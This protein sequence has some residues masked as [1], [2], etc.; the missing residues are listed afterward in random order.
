MKCPSE[1]IE[2]LTSRLKA[3]ISSYV[4]IY[5]Y[6]GQSTLAL[7][8]LSLLRLVGCLQDFLAFSLSRAKEVLYASPRICSSFQNSEEALSHFKK[9]KSFCLF[10]AQQK[11]T[12]V[13]KTL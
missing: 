9:K 7:L 2:S 3:F 12:I 8:P 1:S 4:Y 10:L 5:I 6:I 11:V 13:L